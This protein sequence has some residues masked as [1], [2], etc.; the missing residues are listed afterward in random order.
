MPKIP[1]GMAALPSGMLQ[2]KILLTSLTGEIENDL[3]VYQFF[4]ETSVKNE[5]ILFALTMH[6]QQYSFSKKFPSDDQT[7]ASLIII[8]F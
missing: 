1:R 8:C 5:F 2:K 7:I 6:W 4:Y 3:G